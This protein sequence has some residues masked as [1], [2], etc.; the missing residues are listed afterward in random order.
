VQPV[1]G[2]AEAACHAARRFFKTMPNDSIMVKLDFRNAF[3]SLHRDHMLLALEEIAS[4]Q[5]PYCRLE[6][7]QFGKFTLLLAG[8]SSTGRP[9]GTAAVLPAIITDPTELVLCSN[10][11]LSG[12]HITRRRNCCDSRVCETHRTRM[13]LD[14]TST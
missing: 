4:E 13:W 10:S 2:G 11:W 6:L 14:G 1:P 9:T 7:L 5:T 12:R 8:R 3:D